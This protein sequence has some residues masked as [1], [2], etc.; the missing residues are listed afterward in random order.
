MVTHSW[1]VRRYT[2]GRW[3][4]TPD[5]LAVETILE[6]Y[7]DGEFLRSL[8]FLA[9]N[10]ELLVLG[11][12][13]NAGLI[14]GVHEVETLRVDLERNQAWVTLS[15][16]GKRAPE[17]TALSLTKPILTPGTVLRLADILS[18]N[19]LFQ[20]TGAVHCGLL[21]RQDSVVFST[22]D[23]GRFNVLDKL[24]GFALKE[25][26][27]TE[28]LALTFSGRLTGEVMSRIA[29]MM[30]PVVV[31]PAAP[32]LRGLQIAVAN[33]ITVVGFARGTRFNLYACPERI[34]SEG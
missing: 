6:I 21:A 23:T 19:R 27:A 34:V 25:N 14:S 17:P 4:R 18:Q 26:T 10:P 15:N 28:E 3:E 2:A 31:S 1:Q 8:L 30:V 11:H 16:P 7:L 20:Q 33:N 9:D 22:E 29:R 24:A 13:F 5:D 12:L 32:T